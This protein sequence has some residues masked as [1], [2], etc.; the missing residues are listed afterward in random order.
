MPVKYIAVN[1]LAASLPKPPF[2]GFGSEAATWTWTQK[3][4][5]NPLKL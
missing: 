4:F 3:W 1:F 5:K 2:G